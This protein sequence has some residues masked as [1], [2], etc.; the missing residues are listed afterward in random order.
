MAYT[1]SM[2][3]A[4]ILAIFM[5]GAS[6]TGCIE[7]ED[8][9]LDLRE[10]IEDF[11]KS[12][13]NG[14]YSKY[15]GY[16]LTYEGSFLTAEDKKECREMSDEEVTIEF[17]ISMTDYNA[18]KLDYK[19]SKSSGYVYSISA[20][21]EQCT[22][23]DSTEEWM[24]D[25]WNETEWLWAKVDGK[26]G[27]G[28]D[29][30]AGYYDEEGAPIL[31]MFTQEDSNGWFHVE[32]IKISRYSDLSGFS[33]FLKDGSG[34]T[35]V[36][37]NGFGEIAL[38]NVSGQLLGIGEIYD[39]ND[40]GLNDRANEISNDNGTKWPVHFIDNDRD[41]KLSPG[42]KFLV[43]GKGQSA[44]G[45]AEDGWKLDIQYDATGDIVGSAKLL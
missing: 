44:N 24:C 37:G 14:D 34:T 26:W 35:Y 11:I 10:S 23:Y 27:T 18:E 5:L 33:F 4:Y 43:A 8:D 45:P 3:K 7:D 38:Q 41:D 21:I 6:F 25:T 17:K 42:D 30:F 9:S 31:T 15:C 16:I 29:G 22:R 20:T 28:V 2:N 32:V 39:G 1:K 13:E 36:G 19:A 12:L 40:G